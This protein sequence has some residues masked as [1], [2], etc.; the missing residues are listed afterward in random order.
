MF[1]SS[2]FNWDDRWQDDA[3]LGPKLED[4]GTEVL[5][6]DPFLEKYLETVDEEKNRSVFQ[7]QRVTFTTEQRKRRVS[8][9]IVVK[10]P[11]K[12]KHEEVVLCEEEE[13]LK[14]SVAFLWQKDV[15][16]RQF[17]SDIELMKSELVSME[18]ASL[19]NRL[20]TKTK[21]KR[22][23]RAQKLIRAQPP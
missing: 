1:A 12:K 4:D 21:L 2:V 20:S 3:F 23:L 15:R 10:K 7:K 11:D 14:P 13:E 8:T 16:E 17:K 18:P 19:R 5:A 9:A 22:E 6:P